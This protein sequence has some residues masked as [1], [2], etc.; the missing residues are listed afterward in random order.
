MELKDR[1]EN[2]LYEIETIRTHGLIKYQEKKELLKVLDALTWIDN[3]SKRIMGR[4][5]ELQEQYLKDICGPAEL[6]QI[7]E[8]E[9]SGHT[10]QEALREVGK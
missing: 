2:I 7:K 9:A 4:R 3:F 1:I 8:L 5:Y 10:L 6:K